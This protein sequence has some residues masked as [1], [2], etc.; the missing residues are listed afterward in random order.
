M[1][2]ELVSSRPLLES[3]VRRALAKSKLK[4]SKTK[5]VSFELELANLEMLRQINGV[6][7]L[8]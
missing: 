5:T 1:W 6:E 2:P 3:Y 4:P 7:N 8:Y